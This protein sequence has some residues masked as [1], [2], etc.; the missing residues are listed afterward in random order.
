MTGRVQKV[1]LGFGAFLA[2]AGS[3]PLALIAL[4]AWSDFSNLGCDVIPLEEWAGNSNCEDADAVWKI[5]VAGAALT[6]GFAGA[7]LWRLRHA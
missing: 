5:A 4:A 6:G 3:L 2:L 1:A 7:C